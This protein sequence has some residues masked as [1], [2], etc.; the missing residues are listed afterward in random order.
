MK[1]RSCA[2]TVRAWSNQ[3]QRQ[4]ARISSRA[5]HR[6]VVGWLSQSAEAITTTSGTRFHPRTWSR[7]TSEGNSGFP[8]W[9]SDGQQRGTHLTGLVSNIYSKPLDGST[10][11][12]R[13][14]A[15]DRIAFP[16]SWSPHGMLASVAVQ[17][18]A[19]QSIWVLNR[20]QGG[21]ATSFVET[22]SGE[23]GPTFSSDGR[24]IAYVSAESG[25][26]E[27]YARLFSA[28]QVKR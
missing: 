8:V 16:F 22:G 1:K 6:M 28:A 3:P 20:D 25:R 14:F 21:K 19:V 11:E 24:W 15:S 18:R 9:T 12:E 2:W 26:N 23:G 7:F 10:R 4:G 13:L 5:C 27:I 17:G